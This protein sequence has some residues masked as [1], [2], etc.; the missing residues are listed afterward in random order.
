MTMDT[1]Q[2]LRRV[3]AQ[4]ERARLIIDDPLL[5]GAFEALDARFLLA[6]RN[7]PADKP[8]LRER[9][10][11]HI[12]ALAEVRAEMQTVLDDGSMAR[13]ALEEMRQLGTDTP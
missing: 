11:H 2:E 3:V 5:V 4:A 10:W 1:E 13:A 12:Q 6:W 7:S 9:L 8:E